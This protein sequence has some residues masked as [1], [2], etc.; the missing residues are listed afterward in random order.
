MHFQ[1][2]TQSTV[3]SVFNAKSISTSTILVLIITLDVLFATTTADSVD[4]KHIDGTVAIANHTI[5]TAITGGTALNPI[6]SMSSTK[7]LSRRKRFIAFPEGSS[8]SVSFTPIEH[9]KLL[10]IN[11]HTN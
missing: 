1:M 11:M 4:D 5:A 9:F 6:Q 2:W 8:F 7:V 10:Q 3:G